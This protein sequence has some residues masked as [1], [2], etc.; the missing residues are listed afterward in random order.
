MPAGDRQMFSLTRKRKPKATRKPAARKSNGTKSRTV[1]HQRWIH[2]NQLKRGMYVAELSVPWEE[3]NFMFQGF[4]VN[5]A[6]LVSEIQNV[7]EYALVKTQKV[8][9][10]SNKHAR[11]VCTA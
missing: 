11:Q 4:E 7:A 5:S 3:T 2:T 1:V 9:Q 6:K 8:T 10:L